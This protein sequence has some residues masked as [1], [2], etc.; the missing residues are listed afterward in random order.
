MNMEKTKLSDILKGT[1][2]H[3]DR[4]KQKFILKD[5]VINDIEFYNIIDNTELLKQIVEKTKQYQDGK[6]G[7]AQFFIELIPEITDVVVDITLDEF[8]EKLKHSST[9]FIKFSSEIASYLMNLI[10]LKKESTDKI[11]KLNELNAEIKQM[12]N[13]VKEKMV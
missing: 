6:L 5:E 2:M 11:I 9:M 4:E 1:K 7:Q 8:N 10:K 3:W 12:A 13:E